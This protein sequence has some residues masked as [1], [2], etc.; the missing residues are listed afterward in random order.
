[1]Q[2]SIIQ[3]YLETDLGKRAN[4]I[5]RNC[6]HCGFCNATCPTYQL[7]GDELDGPRGRIY[8]IKQIL[9]GQQPTEK[10]QLHL[11]RCLT[12]RNCETTCPSGVEYSTLIDT[13][14]KLITEKVARSAK[15]RLLH[16]SLRKFL[17]SPKAFPLAIK[18][19]QLFRPLLPRAIQQN[20]PATENKNLD[21]PVIEH[22]RKVILVEGCVQKSL[23]PDTDKTCAIVFNRMNIQSLRINAA[24]C[25]GALSHHLNA[26]AEAHTYIKNNIDAWWP[27]IESG[28]IKAITMTASGC[29]VMIQDYAKLLA[30]DNDYADRA[31]KVGALYKDPCEII[32]AEIISSTGI[33]TTKQ[34]KRIAFHPPCTLQ[35]GLKINGTIENLISALGHELVTFEN[36]HLCCGSAGTY[37]ITQKEISRQLRDNKL[38][39]IENQQ[40]ELIVTANIGCQTHLQGGT[41]TPVRHWLELLLPE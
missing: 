16:F 35:H 26:E 7:L 29:G 4:E 18:T 12:C 25:C 36:K 17:L 10:T 8:L 41:K 37:S 24:G 34:P 27:Y 11:D 33:T 21:W 20:I 32:A 15:Q 5:L 1:M 13:G 19:G 2:T 9:E 14:R 22:T 31:A 38:G 28:E 23:Q 40:P 3:S 39:A 6:V 30:N